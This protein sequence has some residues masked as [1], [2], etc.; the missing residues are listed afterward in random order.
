MEIAWTLIQYYISSV[1]GYIGTFRNL[2][3]SEE[4][5]NDTSSLTHPLNVVMI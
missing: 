5:L 4:D 3:V 2:Y 1:K